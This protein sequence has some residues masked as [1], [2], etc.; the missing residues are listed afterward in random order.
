MKWSEVFREVNVRLDD[1]MFRKM[2]ARGEKIFVERKFTKAE[3][4]Q[5]KKQARKIFSFRNKENGLQIAEGPT[6]HLV[7]GNGGLICGMDRSTL[8]RLFGRYGNVKSL[9]MI[10]GKEFALLSFQT[11]L[12]AVAAHKSLHGRPLSYP[13]EAPKDGITFYLAY[14]VESLD[15][16]T[17][18]VQWNVRPVTANQK[19]LHP[20]GLILVE[21][22]I[23]KEKE[24]ELIE[25]FSIRGGDDRPGKK[26]VDCQQLSYY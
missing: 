11:K 4:K 22:F 24:T 8:L 18:L 9:Y 6:N 16:R 21:D 26:Y 3:R 5:F 23:S 14:L 15:D 19:D 25:Y 20:P 7:I 10:P 12:E 17:D 1:N 2:A 13:D